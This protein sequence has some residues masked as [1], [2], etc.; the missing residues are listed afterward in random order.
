[1]YSMLLIEDI[2]MEQWKSDTGQIVIVHDK[3]NCEGESCCIHNPSDHHMK[4]WPLHWRDD[5]GKMERLCPH[6][7]GH[8]DPDEMAF[9]ER[10][11]ADSLSHIGIHGCDGCCKPPV[12]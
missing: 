4:D 2:R 1:M 7:I 5:A 9:L 6:G 8:P 12:K 10:I 11:N 3:A